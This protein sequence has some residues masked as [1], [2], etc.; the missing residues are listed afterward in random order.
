MDKQT[1]LKRISLRELAEEAG[2]IFSKGDASKCPL[3]GGNNPTA[4]HLYADGQRWHCFTNCP[5]D[6]NDGDAITFYMRWKNVDF[7]TAL[8][9]LGERAG[10][11]HPSARSSAPSG[12]KPD[13]IKWRKRAGEFLNY[14]IV[15]L[16]SNTR[17]PVF[18]Y[19]HK[20]RGLYVQMANDY[21][22]GYNPQDIFDLPERWGL[23]GKKI[24]LPR[25]IV[26]PGLMPDGE[27]VSYI[28]IRRP[29][30]GDS[31]TE[32]IGHPV[33]SLPKVKFGG[34]R[35]GHAVL[36]GTHTM[37]DHPVALLTEGEWD[38]MLAYR[39]ARDLCDVGTLGGATHRADI[40]DLSH[41]TRYTAIIVVYDRDRAGRKGSQY[42]ARI[43][44]CTAVEPPGNDLTDYWK[45]HGDDA[46][47]AWIARHV[48]SAL[49]TSLENLDEKN[50]YNT[51]IHWLRL[52]EKASDIGSARGKLADTPTSPHP[53]RQP[54]F[55]TE[56]AI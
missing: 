23:T 6:K 44:R 24:W 18:E 25:G 22:L 31:L 55:T 36:F 29:L 28:K 20:E 13:V 39:L 12:P 7:K 54:D 17:S 45:A 26:I 11:G 34:P 32:Y 48:A 51:F 30:P 14:A 35:G 49:E 21:K 46:L 3:H 41:L 53:T 2:A 40:T 47:R 8:E 19:L 27:T 1:I 33:T 16:W 37:R 43:P 38:C 4:F 50:H 9:E 52:Y 15:Q 56:T 42:L 5:A 10:L